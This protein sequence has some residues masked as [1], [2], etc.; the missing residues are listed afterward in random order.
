MFFDIYFID[1]TMKN[2]KLAIFLG[3]L[4]MGII[5]LAQED[6]TNLLDSNKVVWESK[7]IKDVE[8]GLKK[9]VPV[10]WATEIIKVSSEY[11]KDD[12]SASQALGRPNAISSCGFSKY[13]WAVKE[14]NGEEVGDEAFIIVGFSNPMLIQQIAIAESFNPGA[15]SEVIIHGINK[16]KQSVY[17][18]DPVASK[19][20]C[21]ML[22]IFME[23][24]SDFMVEKVEI[25]L[26]PGKVPG[27]NQIDA[28]GISDVKDSVKADINNIPNL[29]FDTKPER[30][31]ESINTIY[32]EDAPMISPDGK[33]IY[34]VRKNHPENVGG[35][36][37]RDDIWNSRLDHNGQWTPSRNMGVP[38]NNKH[39]NFVQSITPDGNTILLANI[40]NSDGT[41]GDGV[42]VTYRTKEGWA[43]PE[44]QLIDGYLNLSKYANYY[45]SN[46]GRVLLLAIEGKDSY[47]NLDLYVSFMEGENKW[48]KPRNLSEMLNTP[49][50]D[51]SPFLAADGVTLY[52]SS[53]GYPG[54]GDADIYV[55][56]RLDETWT[57]WSEPQNLGNVVNTPGSDSKYNIPASGEFAY[58]ATEHNSIGKKDIFRIQLPKIAKPQAVVLISGKV[59]NERTN[60]PVDAK[61]IVEE[62][63]DGKEVAIAR[64]DPTTGEFKIILPA[65]KKYGFRAIGLGFFDSNKN[66]DLTDV[67]EYM[68]ITDELLRLNPIE[69]GQVVRLNNIFFET[70]KATLKP[71]SFPEL[72]RTVKFL[73][74]NKNL[75][76]EIAGHTDDVGP[77]DYNMKL[78]KDRAQSVT[79]YII[80][81]GI[82]SKRLI[83]KGYGETRPVAFNQSEEG[84]AMN[85]RVEFKV[86]KK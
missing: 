71:E 81:N 16:E 84:R 27:W 24:P 86:L 59:M 64:T 48:S 28:I 83:V 70:A 22:N 58:F 40:Y 42:S 57:N 68:E 15:I 69:V 77:D 79:N 49:Q 44:K 6:K 60:K 21:R 19:K 51:F 29:K 12:K 25:K 18:A 36:Q 78:S 4:G 61:I 76:I 23:R 1:K 67:D 38:L 73:E 35:Y 17:K 20:K 45:L 82:D 11:S 30:L 46:D 66:I 43:F 80:L 74:S 5:S 41:T 13:A 32:D 34:F 50:N 2:I 47:G 31:S 53:D 33:T 56:S 72:D 85:R 10:K 63:P 65:G 14:K 3:F 8:L 62:L 54:Y 26:E 9:Y 55:T 37:D 39:N 7:E 75:E 52:F